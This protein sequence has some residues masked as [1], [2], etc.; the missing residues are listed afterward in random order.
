MRGGVVRTLLGSALFRTQPLTK[1]LSVLPAS[2]SGRRPHDSPVPIS[3]VTPRLQQQKTSSS[4]RLLFV[5]FCL[6]CPGAPQINP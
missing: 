6:L 5:Y 1:G 2:H 4:P 3:R